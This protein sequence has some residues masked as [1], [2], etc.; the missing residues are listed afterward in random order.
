ML[1]AKQRARQTWLLLLLSTI[2][3]IFFPK[4]QVFE[5]G[6]RSWRRHESAEP[7]L[8][9][10]SILACLP[11]FRNATIT[12]PMYSS[13]YPPIIVF[14]HL[15]TTLVRSCLINFL[16]KE[17]FWL[18][19]EF[20]RLASPP[21]WAHT[22]ACMNVVFVIRAGSPAAQQAKQGFLTL[23]PICPLR[24]HDQAAYPHKFCHAVH[25][26]KQPNRSQRGGTRKYGE[27]LP[28]ACVIITCFFIPLYLHSYTA[29]RPTLL[30]AAPGVLVTR[31]HLPT[32][33]PYDLLNGLLDLDLWMPWL[34]TCRS[35]T[36]EAF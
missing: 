7:L 34:E 23:N 1:R 5:H 6:D 24:L 10:A 27:I 15:G 3:C 14:P 30:L 12:V 9:S 2:S 26:I 21:L 16:S 19:T 20:S 17:L 8:A 11:Q 32:H 25:S 33:L 13:P 35:A 29:H 36:T 22:F 28:L 31:I 4:E 18:S